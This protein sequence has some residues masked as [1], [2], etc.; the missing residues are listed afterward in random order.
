[1]IDTLHVVGTSEFLAQVGTVKGRPTVAAEALRRWGGARIWPAQIDIEQQ[2][3]SM[4][5]PAIHSSHT[6]APLF[7]HDWRTYVIKRIVLT[8]P[9]SMTSMTGAPHRRH[10]MV[11]GVLKRNAD[12]KT[13]VDN[14]L[15]VDIIT[16]AC[17]A[18]QNC[19][20]AV[21]IVH[22]T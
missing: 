4:G 10:L 21:Q 15:I 19:T 3:C 17:A 11:L 1:M 2:K 12:I 13:C 5:R 16:H 6:W 7:V 18:P 9:E 20:R 8:F 14:I 22:L